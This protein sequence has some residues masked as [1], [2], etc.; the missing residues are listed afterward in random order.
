MRMRGR[1]PLS[2]SI[3]TAFVAFLQ[4]QEQVLPCG[5]LALRWTESLNASVWAHFNKLWVYTWSSCSADA[6]AGQCSISGKPAV[7]HRIKEH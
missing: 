3:F 7:C 5:A 4:A 6:F 2:R 1:W